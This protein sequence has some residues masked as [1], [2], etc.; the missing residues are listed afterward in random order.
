M[1]DLKALTNL[2]VQALSVSITKQ[3]DFSWRGDHSLQFEAEVM[4]SALLLFEVEVVVVDTVI[5]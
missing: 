2:V 4:C 1:L 5:H 3:S